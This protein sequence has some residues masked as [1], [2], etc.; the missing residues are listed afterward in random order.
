VAWNYLRSLPFEA[1]LQALRV[2]IQRYNER[3]KKRLK[4][5]YHETL[6]VF[7]A[8][9]VHAGI[10]A[11][12]ELADFDAFLETSFHLEEKGLVRQY[13]SDERL[14]SHEA[15]IQIVEP[16]KRQWPGAPLQS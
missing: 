7:W 3:H 5:G 14:F 6:T 4:V 12:P 8:R 16:D 15:R 11:Q 13:F 1:A 9:A 10:Q 2:G